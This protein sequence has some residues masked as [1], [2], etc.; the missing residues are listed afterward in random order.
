[1]QSLILGQSEHGKAVFANRNF[2]KGNKLLEFKG[3]LLTKEQL[4]TPDIV[5]HSLQVNTNTYLGPSSDLDDFLNHS[6]DP[7]SGVKMKKNQAILV[8]MR[9]IKKS[10]EITL[11]YSTTMDEDEWELDCRCKTKNCR[12]K[13]RDFKYLPKEIQRNYIRL[14]IVPQ[15]ILENL[16]LDRQQI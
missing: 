1:M 4:T 15:Y 16:T 2:K 10:E 5:N 11:D 9:T 13:I 12:K 6:C 8:A 14:G 7:N 3:G